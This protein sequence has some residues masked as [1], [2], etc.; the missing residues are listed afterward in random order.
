MTD[1]ISVPRD[2]LERIVGKC[3]LSVLGDDHAKVWELL[4]AA[5]KAEQP[6][7]QEP[8]ATIQSQ[9]PYDERVGV[10]FALG[11]MERLSALPAGT[12]LYA[13]PQPAALKP[14][15]KRQ[16]YYRMDNCPASEPTDE[17]CICWHD[18]GAGPIVPL[19]PVLCGWREVP[20]TNAVVMPDRRAQALAGVSLFDLGHAKGW[21]ACLD[22]VERLNGGQKG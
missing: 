18:E 16:Y 9:D 6:P 22:E 15:T 19:D 1:N 21:N 12:K 7:V 11:D 3:K 2:L 8:V 5:P 4:A 17:N 13:A 20:V 14:A 10:Y